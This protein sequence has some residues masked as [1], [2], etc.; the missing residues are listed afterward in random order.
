MEWILPIS[1]A[2]RCRLHIKPGVEV[3]IRIVSEVAFAAVHKRL[4]FT[5]HLPG[6]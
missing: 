3:Y 1:L 5:K 2:G 4:V 6:G